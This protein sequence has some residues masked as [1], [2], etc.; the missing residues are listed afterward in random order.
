MINIGVSYP[1]SWHPLNRCLQTVLLVLFYPSIWKYT[2][3]HTHYS[4][5]RFC[6]LKLGFKSTYIWLIISIFVWNFKILAKQSQLLKYFNILCILLLQNIINPINFSKF[7]PILKIVLVLRIL[8]I[9]QFT[10]LTPS[11]NFTNTDGIFWDH[12]R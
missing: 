8:S 5:S 9:L 4:A 3:H 10:K 6:P 2:V 12:P 7:T 11:F 1:F